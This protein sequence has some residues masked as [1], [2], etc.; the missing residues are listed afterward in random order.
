MPR[1]IIDKEETTWSLVQAY[2]GL[3][4]PDG[5]LSDA[6]RVAGTKD[7]VYVVATP[8]GGAQS[9]RLQLKSDWESS[10][11]DEELLEEIKT[12]QK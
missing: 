11:S 7:A 1:E 3:K 10:L 6:A 12:H 4:E 9:V 8:S 5:E 2:A